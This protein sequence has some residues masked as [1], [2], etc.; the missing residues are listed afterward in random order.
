MF[1]NMCILRYFAGWFC[2]VNYK[3]ISF[4]PRE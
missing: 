3:Y 4:A 2:G 1:G